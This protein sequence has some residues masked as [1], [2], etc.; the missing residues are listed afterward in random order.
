M[1]AYIDAAFRKTAIAVVA[2]A[3]LTATA[4][5]Q[6]PMKLK[7]AYW[8]PKTTHYFAG[9]DLALEELERRTG[10]R[11][12]FE[13]YY[14]G[15]LVG[16]REIRMRWRTVS[17]TSAPFCRPIIRPGFRWPISVLSPA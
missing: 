15:S 1:I 13:R 7:V 4:F 10:G 2:L 6:G 9:V 14:S 5:A 11:L 12:Q 3:A 17:P 16:A 8:G